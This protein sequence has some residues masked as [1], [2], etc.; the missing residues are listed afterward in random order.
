MRLAEPLYLLLLLPIFAGLWFSFRRTFGMVKARKRMAFVLR[1]ILASLLVIA[2]AGPEAVRPNV[3]LATIFVIDRSDSVSGAPAKAAETFVDSALQKLGPDDQAGVV[4]FGRTPL[5]ESS[6][7]GR[8]R[9]DPIRS[10]IDPSDSDLAAAVRLATATFP[11][12]KARRLVVLSDGNET[13]G[14]VAGVAQVA[15]TDNLSIDVVSLAAKAS[16]KEVSVVALESPDEVRTDQPFNLRLLVDSSGTQNG[17]V[18]IDRDGVLLRK[19]NVSLTAGTNS[20]VIPEKLPRTGFYRYR[21]TLRTERDGDNRNNV[22][23]SFVAVRGKPRVL[24]LQENPADKTLTAALQKSGLSID[25]GGPSSAPVRPEDF[26][27][28]DAVIFNDVNADSFRPTQLKLVQSA[29]RDSG[30]GFAMVGGENSFLPG[31]YYGTSLA[32]ALPVDLNIRQRKTFPSTSIL[33][34]ADAS[35]SMGMME[36]GV[37]KIRLAA[38]A[39]EETV[40]LLS[41]MDRVGV[42]GSTDGIEFVAPMQKLTDKESVIAQVRRLS[43]GGGGIYVRPSMEKAQEVLMKETSQVRHFI[44]LADGA[45]ADEHDGSVAIALQ[46]RANK[47]T[48]SVVSI[49]RGKDVSFLRELA[50]AGGGRFY[51]ADRASQLPAIFTQDTSIMSRSAIEEGAFLPKFTGD[52]D[53][54]NGID[55]TPPLMAYCLTDSRPLA[56]TLMRTAKD[57]PLLATWQY[58]LGTSVAFTSDA[59]PRWAAK[60]VGWSGCDAFWSQLARG[61]GRRATSNRYQVSVRQNGGKGEL[62][63]RAFDRLGNPLTTNGAKVRVATPKGDPRDVAVTQRAPGVFTGS[64][65]ANELGSYI[66]TVAE[67]DG[68]GKSRVSASGFS[69]PYPP[70]YRTKRTNTPLLTALAET[71]GGKVLKSP[72][73]AL[74]PVADPGGSISELWLW[75][76]GL[77]AAL[78]PLDIAIRRIALPFGAI[79]AAILSWI[80]RRGVKEEVPHAKVMAQLKTVRQ[81]TAREAAPKPEGSPVVP[82]VPAPKAP[83]SKQPETKAPTPDA[84][85]TAN[86]LLEAKRR[87]RGE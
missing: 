25:L 65:D 83:D 72:E 22:G 45:D 31:G 12:G 56:R 15:S 46:M 67:S 81:R 27:A 20:I 13:K 75:F 71:T 30:V 11:E 49:G 3:G 10:D 62:E 19:I 6:P 17:Q 7:G 63:L 54:L 33:I 78:L 60:W 34:M 26:Q 55:G 9:L 82:T 8:R 2:L 80:P 44:L 29:I 43:T 16:E 74:R 68:A 52:D 39:A 40:K 70:E 32:E 58:G 51:L 61:I 64:F 73:E 87:R 14:D 36:D 47:I 38:M 42:A 41:P 59:Q 79:W 57:D 77:A 1:A 48:T 37:Q 69:V 24:V 28:Y 53:I 4:V 21:A 18:E 76:V 23:L 86:A 66:V 84:A 5:V 35:G 85:N 50:A